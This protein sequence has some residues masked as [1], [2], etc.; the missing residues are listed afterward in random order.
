VLSNNGSDLY[1]AAC[2]H[3]LAGHVDR[4]FDALDRAVG[5]GYRNVSQLETDP[6]LA[7]LRADSR[8]AFVLRRA[9]VIRPSFV[10]RVEREIYQLFVEQAEERSTTS[11]GP[12]SDAWRRNRVTELVATG[13]A[14]SA[15]DYYYAALILLGSARES[16]LRRARDWSLRAR[17]LDPKNLAAARL[18]AVCEE[19]LLRAQG[20]PQR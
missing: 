10:E 19:K 14:K 12:A 18:S 3:S 16:D 5:A 1:N 6:D 15:E 11:A 17:G 7:P 4:A 2:C 20:K 9:Q 8:W 13:R